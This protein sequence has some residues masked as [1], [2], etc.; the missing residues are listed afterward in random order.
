LVAGHQHSRVG[1]GHHENQVSCGQTQAVR[2]Q[3]L[4]RLGVLH[5]SEDHHHRSPPEPERQVGKGVAE[6]WLDVVGLDRIQSLGEPAHLRAPP[7]RL[8]EAGD[9]VVEGHETDAV[10]VSVGDPRKHQGG[11]DCVIELVER[12]RGRSHQAAAIKRDHHLLAAFRLDLDDHRMVAPGCRRP[13]H[14]PY[15]VATNVVPESG[16]GR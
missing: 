3:L 15:V 9:A 5:V 13:A 4:R 16:E 14:A 10:A 11:V 7:F 1:H 8:D 6:V 2:D 12:A